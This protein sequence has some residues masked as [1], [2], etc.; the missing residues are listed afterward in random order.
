[1]RQSLDRD[2]SQEG[3]GRQGPRCRALAELRGW[4]VVTEYVDND[5]SASKPRGPGTAW[6]R[7]IGDAKAG[8][9]EV[10]IAVDQD[11]LL[12]SLGDL[13]TL[14]ELG[15][16]V[17]TVDGEID[18]A[19]ADGEFRATMAAGLARFEVRRKSER[20]LRANQHRR[21]NK[22][23]SGGR[24]AFGYTKLAAGAITATATRQGADGREWPAYGHEPLEP[25]ATAVRRGYDM[26]LAGATLRSI[27][28][29][30]NEAG[31]MT[32]VARDWE[33][34]AVDRKSVV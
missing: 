10:I 25:E 30:W 20:Q 16:K 24:R 3:V 23:P 21:E 12:R 1:M 2:N 26:L 8:N 7:L 17:V 34:Y 13:V 28:R 11:R 6:H 22:L 18:L 4:D 32:T 9:V 5:V 19:S 27:A 15:V 31:L 29:A 14:I 33:P